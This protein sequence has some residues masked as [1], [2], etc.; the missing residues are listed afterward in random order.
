MENKSSQKAPKL[1]CGHRMCHSCLKRSFELSIK[2]PQHMPPKCC[3]EDSISLKHVE[4]LFDNNFKKLW[5]RKSAEYRT[6]N[7]VYCPSKKCGEWIKPSLIKRDGQ[8]HSARCDRCNT[9]VCVACN[10]KWH[11]SP[12]CP[13]DEETQ[14]FLRQAKEEGWQR[15]YS[16]KSMVERKQGCNHMTWFVYIPILLTC[17]I[18]AYPI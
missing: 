7:R 10:G 1:K 9:K 13:Q 12:D 18:R 3:T 8:R 2:D 14:R 17:F 4:A 6:K 11:S 16:C 5:N 15:C